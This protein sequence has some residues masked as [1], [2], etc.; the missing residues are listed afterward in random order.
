MD[1]FERGGER[2]DVFGRH[3][4]RVRRGEREHRADAL[5]AGQQRVAHRLLEA[6]RARLVAEAQALEIGLDVGAQ[7][8][9]VA[10]LR[11][12]G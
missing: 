3:P 2:E 1:E 8:V 7:V 5:A 11:T 10:Q 6:V 4:D 9:R 12:P